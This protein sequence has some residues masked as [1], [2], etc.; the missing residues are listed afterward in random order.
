MLSK[1]VMLGGGKQIKALLQGESKTN[2]ISIVAMLLVLFLLRALVVQFAYN[3]V[4]PP[5]I[6]HWSSVS[7]NDREFKPLMFEEALLFTILI[8]F[9][10]M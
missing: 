3:K 10:W 5:L 2:A 1:L 6:R 7:E 4:A 9:L 8:S